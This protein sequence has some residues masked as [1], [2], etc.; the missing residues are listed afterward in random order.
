MTITKL[1]HIDKKVTVKV[2]IET[3]RIGKIPVKLTG[4]KQFLKLK[5]LAYWI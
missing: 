3:E 5:E 4:K 1:A 2:N